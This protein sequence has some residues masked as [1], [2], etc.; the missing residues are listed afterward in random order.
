MLKVT[1]DLHELED[2]QNKFKL[3]ARRA[4]PYAT[5]FALNEAAWESRAVARDTI[6][7]DFVVRRQR[8][9]QGIRAENAKGNQVDRQVSKVGSVDDY[10]ARQ[11]SGGILRKKGKVAKQIYTARSAGL[12]KNA[13]PVTKV[14][15]PTNRMGKSGKLRLLKKSKDNKAWSKKQRA[16]VRVKQALKAGKRHAM[17]EVGDHKGIFRIVGKGKVKKIEMVQNMEH[18]SVTTPPKPWLWPSVDR[19]A[20]QLPR[21]Y[22]KHLIKQAQRHRLFGY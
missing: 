5:R 18:Q 6:R 14:A 11:E 21:I 2:L 15:L 9:L 13:R 17:L 10:M 1:V 19:V 7:K 4:Y 22:R 8:P 3:F 12:P 16:V 20:K